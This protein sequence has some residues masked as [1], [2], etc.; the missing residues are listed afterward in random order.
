MFNTQTLERAH[1]RIEVL[2]RRGE[3]NVIDH[4]HGNQIVSRY[5]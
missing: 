1:D 2:N 4:L 5:R 3:E